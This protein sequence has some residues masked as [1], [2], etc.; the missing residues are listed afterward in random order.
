[1]SAQQA[2]PSI[3]SNC[4]QPLRSPPT[5]ALTRPPPDR[6]E[7]SA[8]CSAQPRP[9]PCML[10][11]EKSV[12]DSAHLPY[13]SLPAVAPKH[14]AWQVPQSFEESKAKQPSN[15]VASAKVTPAV[16]ISSPVH[17]C[18]PA[19]QIADADGP[20]TMPDHS[21]VHTAIRGHSFR[22]VSPSRVRSAH[23]VSR[24][25]TTPVRSSY[26]EHPFL[27]GV[28]GASVRPVSRQE[29]CGSSVRRKQPEPMHSISGSA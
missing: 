5:C 14:V 25:Q 9:I 19:A 12:A 21:P 10:G 23:P 16:R 28:S 7:V 17:T 2:T 27:D 15:A 13:S 29:V 3:P 22:S 24:Q 8:G 1:M 26:H 11:P 4:L 18:Q 20:P 6:H